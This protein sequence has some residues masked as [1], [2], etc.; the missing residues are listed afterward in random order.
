MP[1]ALFLGSSLASVDRIDML[2]LPPVLSVA[3]SHRLPSLFK[4][5]RSGTPD[6]EIEMGEAPVSTLELSRPSTLSRNGSEMNTSKNVGGSSST[7]RHRKTKYEE[8]VEVYE[9][10]IKSFDRIQWVDVHLFH[11]T[12]SGVNAWCCLALLI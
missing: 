11:A 6:S 9:Q 2:P 12:A 1:H 10:E 4:R 8:E 7:L 3:K 5:R